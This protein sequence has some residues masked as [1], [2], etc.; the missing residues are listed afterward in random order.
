MDRIGEGDKATGECV[1][2]V[3]NVIS[4]PYSQRAMW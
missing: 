3:R 4:Q 1:M 2:T